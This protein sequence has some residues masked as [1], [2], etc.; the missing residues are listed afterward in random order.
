[1]A[2]V[3]PENG[4]CVLSG[5]ERVRSDPPRTNLCSSSSPE[6]SVGRGGKS[7]GAAG[8]V[9]GWT[10]SCRGSQKSELDGSVGRLV[11]CW[12]VIKDVGTGEGDGEREGQD[13]L[14]DSSSDA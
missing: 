8:D 2:S 4:A 5:V 10:V 6:Q 3:Q 9:P 13:A 14:A 1:M 11:G 7:A 12:D